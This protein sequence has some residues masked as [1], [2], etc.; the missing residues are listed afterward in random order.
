VSD[1]SLQHVPVGE[2]K[3]S[4]SS[5]A[6]ATE[7]TPATAEGAITI[8]DKKIA[9]LEDELSS[10][11]ENISGMDMQLDSIRDDV[12]KISGKVLDIDRNFSSFVKSSEEAM[13]QTAV[14]FAGLEEKV[15]SFDG[16]IGGFESSLDALQI[17]N[18]SIIFP[19]L[20]TLIQ[21]CL[22]NCTS[23]SRRMDRISP[24]WI[25]CPPNLMR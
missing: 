13:S 19:S 15:D 22:V 7:M 16:R 10:F 2:N 8:E 1:G 14:K 11:K 9:S 21:R 17:D 3:V 18:L 12:E 20:L 23:L 25:L 24:V 6:L 5:S 4:S